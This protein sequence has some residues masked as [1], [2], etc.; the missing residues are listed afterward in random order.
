MPRGRN[1]SYALKATLA[2]A[3]ASAAWIYFSD[4]M[5]A[6]ITDAATMV[7]LGMF[8]GLFYVLMSSALLYVAFLR[9][10][11]DCHP[12]RTAPGSAA[13]FPEPATATI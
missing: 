12:A 9:L 2:Y 3:A 5:L 10:P 7:Q 8:K 11:V 4:A 1:T 13:S 6:S